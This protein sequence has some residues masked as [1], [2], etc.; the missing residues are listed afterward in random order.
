VALTARIVLMALMAP[1]A[2]G[3]PVALMAR[4]LIPPAPR[5]MWRL[6]SPLP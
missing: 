3:G 2:F 1:T 6:Q 4:R 5:L